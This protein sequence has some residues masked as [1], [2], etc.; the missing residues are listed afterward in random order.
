[1]ESNASWENLIEM[2]L[3]M[4]NFSRGLLLILLF[5]N[6]CFR[7]SFGGESDT[8]DQI[9]KLILYLLSIL[10][11]FYCSFRFSNKERARYY[12]LDI[13]IG[14]LFVLMFFSLF[15]CVLFKDQ[16]VLASIKVL[17][18][19]I[20]VYGFY[21]FLRKVNPPI[22][23]LNRLFIVLGTMYLICI[24]ADLLSF[25]NF[26]F[27]GGHYDPIRGG[28]RINVPGMFMNSFVFFYSLSQYKLHQSKKYIIWALVSYI[29][30]WALLGRQT[31]VFSTILGLLF[32]LHGVRS[33]I[34]Y[35]IL[36]GGFIVLILPNIPLVKSMMEMQK[37]ENENNYINDTEDI[38]TLD[39]KFFVLEYPRNMYQYMFG[40][41][42][43]AKGT[44]F[45]NE[46]E[47]LF[48]DYHYNKED[49]GWAGF[50]FSY[51]LFSTLL[52]VVV[53]LRCLFLKVPSRY[54]FVKYQLLFIALSAIAGGTNLYHGEYM[55]YMLCFYYIEKVKFI[56]YDTQSNSLLLV[57]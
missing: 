6:Y 55:I 11:L 40:M 28:I 13:K 39:Y 26:L 14:W 53:I 52:L 44:D 54:L 48:E 18:P 22:S 38:R 34:R 47:G 41:G 8:I 36:I 37:M 31:I 17:L 35:F 3:V 33:K 46:I 56:E 16:P 32:I 5:A 21:Y 43:N 50:F 12:Q 1:M 7:P 23:D 49:A 15:G 27:G 19:N 25:P 20:C 30:I 57:R 42:V 24:A 51:G 4:S 45:G 2:F 10:F 9:S 29:G